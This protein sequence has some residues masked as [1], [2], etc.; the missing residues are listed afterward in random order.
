MYAEVR[1]VAFALHRVQW[2]DETLHQWAC[3]CVFLCDYSKSTVTTIAVMKG[4][5]NGA[6]KGGV[7]LLARPSPQASVLFLKAH[8]WTLDWTQNCVGF[9]YHCQHNRKIVVIWEYYNFTEQ[10]EQEIGSGFL[11]SYTVWDWKEAAPCPPSLFS[12]PSLGLLRQRL[13]FGMR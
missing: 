5:S 9:S 8:G 3:V 7:T 2:Q 13:M 4:T 12:I 11:L 10:E 6:W 1:N